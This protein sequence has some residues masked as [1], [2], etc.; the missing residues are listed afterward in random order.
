LILYGYGLQIEGVD[1]VKAGTLER[2]GGEF[3]GKLAPG[4]T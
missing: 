4:A 2:G 3:I 1:Q